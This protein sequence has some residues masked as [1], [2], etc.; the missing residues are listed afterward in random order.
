[1]F[2]RLSALIKKN[3]RR[4]ARGLGGAKRPG[5]VCPAPTEVERR[6]SVLR[7]PKW[8]GDNPLADQ[9]DGMEELPVDVL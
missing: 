5:D 2:I 3:A 1:M 4:G 6:P 9:M 7:G 8:N